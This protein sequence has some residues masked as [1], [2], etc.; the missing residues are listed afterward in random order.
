MSWSNNFPCIATYTPAVA[1]LKEPM[2][3][4]RLNIASVF[5]NPFIG[6]KDPVK[7]TFLLEFVGRFCFRNCAK[8]TIANVPVVINMHSCGAFVNIVCA[9]C[10]I[11]GVIS[12]L[13]IMPID[14]SV[15]SK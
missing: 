2:A 6:V 9:F 15:I 10:M 14:S 5:V 12:R 1:V 13:S 4:P 7:M 11:D 8:L 3:N